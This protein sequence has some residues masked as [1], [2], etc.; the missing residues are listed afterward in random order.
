ML[1][2]QRRWVASSRS[3]AINWAHLGCPVRWFRS[4]VYS[5]CARATAV[6]ITKDGSR[7]SGPP[8]SLLH[9]SDILQV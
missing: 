6:R 9:C 3:F 8:T 4:R 1:G 5:H 7:A 2:A